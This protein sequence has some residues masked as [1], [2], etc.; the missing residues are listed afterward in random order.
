MTL[1]SCLDIAG[2]P[3]IQVLDAVFDK[4]TWHIINFYHD[5]QDNTCLRMLLALDINA[6]TPTLIAGDFNTHSLA[7]SPPDTP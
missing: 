4:E 2:H 5:V 7:W 3:C 1:V 6:T